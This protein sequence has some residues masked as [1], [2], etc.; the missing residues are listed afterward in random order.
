MSC[1]LTS[2]CCKIVYLALIY[3]DKYRTHVFNFQVRFLKRNVYELFIRSRA[4][5]A[6]SQFQRSDMLR[7]PGS[8]PADRCWRRQ[9]VPFDDTPLG[10]G[11]EPHP[12]SGRIKTET[13]LLASQGVCR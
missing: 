9:P 6:R 7:S 2:S 5:E 3:T 1:C 12:V 10:G 11:T 13:E 8:V 4:G